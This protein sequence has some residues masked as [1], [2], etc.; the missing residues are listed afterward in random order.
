[1]SMYSYPDPRGH[2]GQFGGRYVAETL[3]PAL[4]ELEQAYNEA[5][6]D[7][8]FDKEFH[9]YLN[10][11]VGRPSPLYFA[12]RLTEH[13][14]GA[15]IY[16]KREDLNHT[17]AHKVNNTVGQ[18]L[19]AKR[20][21]KKKVIAETG[22]GQHGVATATVAARFGLECEVFMGTEDIRRQSLNVFR[23]KLLGAKVHGVTS[24]TATL[25]DA[26]NDALRHW[27][28]HVRDTFYVI[29]TVAGPHP[30]PQLVR[31]F[32]AVIGRE[33]REQILSAEGKLPDAVVA[34][35]GG[36]S[37]AM[38][39]FYPF[40]HDETVRLLGVEAAGLGIDT[41]KHAASISAGK[42][43]VLHGNKTFLLQ[44]DDGQITHAHSIS[45][46][47][48][49]PGVGP[50][51]AL[52]HD[53]KRAEYE[54][55]TDDEALDG[56]KKLTQ[57][58]GIIPALESAHAVAQVIKLAPTMSKEQIVIMNLSGR[59]DKDMHTVAEAFGVEL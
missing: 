29:G 51:H 40:I 48:D 19:L 54:A 23:M 5:I 32:Q 24:G 12:E 20:M 50:E 3:M 34:C 4:L 25:K 30:Y 55:I 31:D 56:F 14:G 27:V 52:L 39:I 35:I 59:G 17:G 38:G 37:N 11:Y 33:A 49:Y 58:E 9:Y 28:T 21:G 16:L 1:M 15:K 13:L 6:A 2:F 18:V 36:G 47:L 43:G 41:D 10:H 26:M 8:E 53:I 57:L 46:G 44:D 7:P 45:A 42:V 22:A